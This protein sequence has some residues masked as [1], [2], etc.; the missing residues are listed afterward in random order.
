LR[1]S[2]YGKYFCNNTTSLLSENNIVQIIT[3]I[4]KDNI[5]IWNIN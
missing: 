1:L 3:A 4:Y 5:L 2:S